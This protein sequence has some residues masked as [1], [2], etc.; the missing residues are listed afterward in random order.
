MSIQPRPRRAVTLT[1]PERQIVTSI[2][3]VCPEG[4]GAN[5]ELVRGKI[6]RLFPIKDHPKSLICVRG[7]HAREIVYSPDR[8]R[9]PQRR[10][11]GRGEGRFERVSWGEAL[12]GIAER[13]LEIKAAHGAHTLLAHTGRGTFDQSMMDMF[14]PA[15]TINRGANSLLFALGSP[16]AAGVGSICFNSYGQIAPVTV[17]GTTV[18]SIYPD[19]EHAGLIVVWGANPDT[20]SPPTLMHKI[21]QAQ[22]RGAKLIVIDPRRSEVAARSDHWI[23]IRSGTDGALALAMINIIIKEGLYD[24]GFVEHWTEGFDQLREYARQFPP[25]A[26]ARITGVPEDIILETA[27][28]IVELSPA[29]LSAYTG[30][31]YTNSGVQNARAIFILWAIT[32]NLDV[33]GGIVFYPTGGPK[34]NRTDVKRPLEPKPI[35]YD[36]YPLF[37]EMTRA[38]HMMEV[39]RAVLEG[40]PYPIKGILN[41]GSS[42][43]TS[44]PQTELWERTLAKLD[45]FV[46][47]DRFLTA[48]ARYADFLLPATTGFENLAYH[49]H[50]GYVQLRQRVI[51]PQGEARNDVVICAQLAQ[52]LGYGH[53]YPQDEEAMLEFVFRDSPVSIQDLRRNPQGVQYDFCPMEYRKYETGQLRPDGRP[54][55]NTPSGKVEICSRL[56]KQY[57][58]DGLPIYIEPKEGPLSSPA[59]LE[60]YPLVFNSGARTQSAFRSQHLNIP[61]L[62]KMQPEP[63]VLIH[64]RDAEAR[65]IRGGDKVW[66]ESPRG[67]VPFT[68]RVTQGI[69][70]GCIEANMGGGGPLQPEAWREANVNALTD[71]TNRDPISG[72]PVL[73]AL[74]CEVRKR[75]A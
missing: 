70:P 60:R 67:R 4:C 16:N 35:G 22:K 17:F 15:G 12:D 63:L 50:P 62:L 14:A 11:G 7:Q 26:A 32:G 29:A 37:V 57:G 46:V 54:G 56:L 49:K 61:G 40:D 53:L 6:E 41:F 33:Q 8:L 51:D 52:R 42:I 38:A 10:V 9:Y 43:L 23:P 18:K 75:R 65:G 34:F 48:D 55:F 73:K 71:A 69:M 25:A 74:L 20:D 66:L 72:F 13:M 58:Y 59:L 39:P 24:A 1:K 68:A 30:L 3:G 5:V 47:V 2:C 64:P 44:Y 45:L 36:R 21:V 27:R 31:E 28:T 19:V